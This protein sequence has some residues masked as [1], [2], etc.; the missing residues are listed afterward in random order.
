MNHTTILPSGKSMKYGLFYCFLIL[1]FSV[2]AFSG[3][4]YNNNQENTASTSSTLVTYVMSPGTGNIAVKIE[5]PDT[6]RY[7]EGAPIVVEVSTWFV[8]FE[9]FHRVN[10]TRRI[11]VVTLSYLWP[12]REDAATGARS[13]GE[14]DYGGPNSL[15]VLRDVIRFACGDIPDIDGKTIGDLVQMTLLTSN[16][17]LFA[18][19]HAGV[20]ATNVLAHHGPELPGVKYLVGRENPTRDE[21]YPLE[22]GYF[23][24][25]RHPVLNPFYD[26]DDYSPTTLTVDYSTVGWY[27]DGQSRP[28]PYFAA[29]DTLPG[30]ILHPTISPRLFGKRYYSHAITQA[31]LDNGALTPENWPGDLAT[32]AETQDHWPFRTT[33]HNYP[34]IGTALPNLKV[35]I[36]F[37]KD[38]HV[39]AARTKPHIHQAWDGFRKAAGLWVRMN[40]DRAYANSVNSDY[41]LNFPDNH[42]Q[43]E[44]NDWIY[45][46]D[47]GFPTGPGTREDIWLASVAEMADRVQENNWDADLDSVFYPVLVELGET[48]VVAERNRP[49]MEFHLEQNYPN[50]FN[51][52][53]TIIF[54]ITRPQHVTIKIYDILGR[55]IET[56]LNDDLK[57]G[58]H[59]LV[60]NGQNLSS[61]TYICCLKTENL[62]K[63]IKLNLMK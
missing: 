27:D 46:R 10:D 9:G 23:D 2:S 52:E 5:P 39:Q 8:A 1:N 12:G 31:L 17:G 58:L 41:Q 33:V 3:F 48:F 4:S 45:I 15:K 59:E 34:N 29:K 50:P 18:S 35:M 40:P 44:P 55:E 42:A 61:G 63:S 32:P 26:E 21:M 22:I 7:P 62:T 20:V 11:G 57:A 43:N 47:Y 24:D 6:P 14:Y 60:W 37:S 53:T 54:N 25:N 38:D 56:I 30:H 36:V 51:P 28:R 19:S 49:P 13:E 16:V